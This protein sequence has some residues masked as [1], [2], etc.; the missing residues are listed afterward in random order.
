MSLLDRYLLRAILGSVGLVMAVLLVLGALFLLLDQQDDIGVGTYTGAD[1][2]R[3]VLLGLPQ[4]IYDLLPIGAL[5]GALVGLGSL[6]RGSE[7][8]VMRAAGVSV[9]RIAGAAAVAG[10]LLMTLGTLLGEFLA[11]PLQ[12]LARQQKAFDKFT[13]ISFAGPGGAWLRD[14]NLIV[15]VGSQAAEQVFGGVFVFELSKDHELLAIGH[16][17][18]A[19]T[20]SEGSWLLRDYAESR[21]TGERVV[22][23]RAPER[24]LESSVGAEFLGVTMTDPRYLESRTLYR[25]IRHLG[26]NDLDT[27]AYEFAFWSRIARTVAIGVAV[28]LAIPFVFGSLRSAGAGART[29]VGLLLGVAFFLLQRMIESGA[30]VFELD[31]VLLAWLPTAGLALLTAVLIARTR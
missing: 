5:V 12:Q 2:T 11:P 1:A 27:R 23:M 28:L 3:F 24:Q 6:A 31:P 30:I 21:F 22:P 13:G 14:G 16:A 9:L 8:T 15:N 19:R 7:L 26:G 4:L 17:P 10:L 18:T 20:M 29:L 25:L